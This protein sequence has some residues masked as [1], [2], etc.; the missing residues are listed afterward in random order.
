VTHLGSK[1]VLSC[2]ERLRVAKKKAIGDEAANDVSGIITPTGTEKAVPNVKA[3]ST[4]RKPRTPKRKADGADATA[5]EAAEE[6][7][8]PSKKPRK[9][10]TPKAKVNADDGIKTNEDDGIKTNEDDGIKNNADDGMQTEAKDTNE[11]TVAADGE[12]A[13]VPAKKT[14]K[15]RTPKA[16]KVEDGS[17]ENNKAEDGT[18]ASTKKPRARAAPKSKAGKKNADEAQKTGFDDAV[19]TDKAVDTTTTTAGKSTTVLGI[20]AA[21]SDA[22]L[23]AGTNDKMDDVDM[24]DVAQAA[25]AEI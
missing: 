25:L 3:T 12:E 17:A 22:A 15:P 2:K 16:K 14:R 21:S 13:A 4:P 23:K 5:E 20:E 10:R 11:A 9:P 1:S 8:T 6:A 19:A 18:P 7:E 24:E